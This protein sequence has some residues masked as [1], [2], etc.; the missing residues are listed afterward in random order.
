[1]SKYHFEGATPE[2]L[3]RSLLKTKRRDP[4]PQIRPETSAPC[5]EKD[6]TISNENPDKGGKEKQEKEH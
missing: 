4:K 6:S 2:K 3:A 5:R 1:M